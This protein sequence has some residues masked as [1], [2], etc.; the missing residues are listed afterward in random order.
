MLT[1]LHGSQ[2]RGIGAAVCRF[3]P[4]VGNAGIRSCA[5]LAAERK[6]RDLPCLYNPATPNR[7]CDTQFIFLIIQRVTF[8]DFLQFAKACQAPH[9]VLVFRFNVAFDQIFINLVVGMVQGCFCR[10]RCNTWRRIRCG[11]TADGAVFTVQ[12]IDVDD[13]IPSRTP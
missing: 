3:H 8:C 11:R 1:A 10:Q 4:T 2:L 13:V 12:L 6:A 7:C 9:R 5:R